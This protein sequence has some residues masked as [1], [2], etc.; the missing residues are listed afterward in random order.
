[1]SEHPLH[2][3]AYRRDLGGGL[4]L[5]WS[6]PADYE[7]LAEL[8]SY[9]FRERA[10]DPLNTRVAAWTRDLISGRHPLIEPGDFAL[11][12]ETARGT[13]VAA[14]CL[15]WQVWDY[16][17]ISF[18][19]GRPE[20]VATHPDY[21]NR[22]LIR[23]IFELIHARSA[24]RGHMA[25]AI[26]GIAYYYRQFGYEYALDLSGTRRV[27]LSA[28]PKLKEGEQELY[29]LRDATLEE[30]PLVLQLYERERTRVEGGFP[31]LV[32]TRIGEDYWRFTFDGHSPESGE[33]W[34]THFIQ[35]RER[36]P[37]GYVLT[38]HT[39]WDDMLPVV[40]MAVQPGVSLL[41]VMPSVLRALQQLAPTVPTGRPDG[42][43]ANTIGF[44]LG[45]SHPAYTALGDSLASRY[46][47]PY[48][49]YVRVP[50]LPAFI[51]HIAPALEQRLAASPF[52]GHSGEMKLDFYRGGLRLVFENGRLAAA[53]DW[54]QSPAWGPRPQA[55]FPPLVFLQLLFG[56]RS[57]A[58]LRHAFPDVWADDVASKLLDALFPPRISWV[59]PL[60]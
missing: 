42:P 11:V 26:T 23:A 60:D 52:S 48:A 1:M 51:R 18:P 15:M 45:R 4:V 22:G 9:V 46:N 2:D 19:I 50:D 21:R 41:A 12:E 27:Y 25:Q 31:I 16:A 35:D 37:L 10:E 17:G 39:R 24:A 59:M 7:R 38:K 44:V 29:T 58:E 54:R 34:R 20:I 43:S 33:G 6:T 30:L 5:R 47:P 56:H 28:I 8:Y 32:S 3:P 57:L 55:G 13:I 14:T 40:G 49:W 36:Q 53:E